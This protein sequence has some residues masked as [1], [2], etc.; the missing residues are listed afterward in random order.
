MV[1]SGGAPAVVS[2]SF[3]VSSKSVSSFYNIFP[4]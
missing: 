2:S 1:I 4:I 3:G